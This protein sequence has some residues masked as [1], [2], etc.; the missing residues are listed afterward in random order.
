MDLAPDF[1]EFFALLTEH[2]VEF[3]VVGAYALALH[4]SAGA[5]LMT[6]A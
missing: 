3:V 4:G 6:A 5:R 2:H 1:S